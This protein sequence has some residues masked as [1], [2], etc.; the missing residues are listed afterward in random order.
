MSDDREFRFLNL[1]M[2]EHDY[3]KRAGDLSE[4]HQLAVSRLETNAEAANLLGAPISTGIKKAGAA[5]P[6]SFVCSGAN[7][8]N[9]CQQKGYA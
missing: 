9:Y 3:H 6:P 7:Q 8:S 4:A 1:S 2:G 5:R